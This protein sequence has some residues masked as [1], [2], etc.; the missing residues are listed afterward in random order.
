MPQEEQGILKSAHQLSIWAAQELMQDLKKKLMTGNTI[1][2]VN[3]EFL[4]N[5]AFL[6]K[7]PI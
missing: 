1:V 5:K 2:I 3:F 6:T 7:L 4:H